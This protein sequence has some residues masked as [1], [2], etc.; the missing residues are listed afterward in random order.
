MKP[1]LMIHEMSD[2]LLSLPLESYTLTFDD[3]LYSQYYYFDRIKD[4]KTTKIYFVSSGIVC[5]DQMQS[6]VPITCAEA[7][8]KAFSGNKEDY[9]TLG[10]IKELMLDPTVIIGAH[11][12]SHTRLSNFKTLAEKVIYIDKDTALMIKW[13]EQHLGF[14]PT[15]FCFPYNEDLNGLY[16]GILKKWG[17]TDFYGR[18]RIPVETLLHSRTQPDN[19]DISTE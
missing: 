7:H 19:L 6:R 3:G 10:Q 11:S 13:F 5:T 2:K 8:A 15:S 16:K 4:L 18:E 12:H 9:M 1:V 17:F 14:R